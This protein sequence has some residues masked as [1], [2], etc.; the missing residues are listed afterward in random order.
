[1]HVHRMPVNTG[2]VS[3]TYAPSLI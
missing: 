1:M 2:P 3:N